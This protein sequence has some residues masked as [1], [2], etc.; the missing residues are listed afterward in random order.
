MTGSPLRE[1]PFDL[2]AVTR[3][4]L[5]LGEREAVTKVQRGEL[6]RVALDENVEGARSLA[7]LAAFRL[8]LDAV[9][10]HTA[11]DRWQPGQELDGRQD[12]GTGHVTGG[13]GGPAA[14]RGAPAR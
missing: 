9:F 10:S 14:V 7:G 6:F 11:P 3:Y 1:G 4:V 13:R 2:D 5:G 8:V 12:Q